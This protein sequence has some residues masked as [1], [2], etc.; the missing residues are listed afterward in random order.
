ML[1]AGEHHVHHLG[2]GRPA[3]RPTSPDT[4]V[5]RVV[6]VPRVGEGTRDS[7]PGVHR[8]RRLPFC[9]RWPV[10]STFRPMSE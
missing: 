9:L 2:L 10:R 1:A 3:A 8:P 4:D 5:R 6:A 7:S